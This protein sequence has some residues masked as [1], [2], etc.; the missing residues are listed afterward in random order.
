MPAWKI[1]SPEPLELLI[2]YYKKAQSST[3]IDW[4]ILAAINLVETGMGRIVGVS[5]ANARGPMQFLPSTW[6]EIGIG[7][8]GDINDSHDS[9]QAAARY[10]VRRGGLL[11]I[12]KALWGYNNNYS[13]VN[14]VLHYSTL[15]KQDPAAI[16]GLYYWEIHYR[17]KEGDLW[18]P[19]GYS[20]NK[21]IP[22]STY[23]KEVP[24]SAPPA[25]SS[26]TSTKSTSG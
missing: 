21:K 22:I 14:A 18:L 8:D 17:V 9:I 12:R 7:K 25:Y 3:G 2:S 24:S 26:I 20:Q 1:V 16:T 11:D 15:I 19:V 5:T 4:E 13:Y 6:A 23:L 10:L